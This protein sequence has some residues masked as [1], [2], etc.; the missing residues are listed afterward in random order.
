M[1]GQPALQRYP[2]P[3]L[4]LHFL[5]VVH[6]AIAGGTETLGIGQMVK[7]VLNIFSK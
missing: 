1:L 5:R 3:D 7:H 2:G 6:R 4:V